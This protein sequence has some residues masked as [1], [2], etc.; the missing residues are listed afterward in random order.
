MLYTDSCRG[1]VRR[2]MP[3]LA[4]VSFSMDVFF[5]KVLVQIGEMTLYVVEG[6]EVGI[7]GKEEKME[8]N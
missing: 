3:G 5:L 8:M 6:G 4:A 1:S 7:L 2:S